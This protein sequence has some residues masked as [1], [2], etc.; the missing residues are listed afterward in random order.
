MFTEQDM[1]EMTAQA[2][3]AAMNAVADTEQPIIFQDS[4]K[5]FRNAVDFITSPEGLGLSTLYEY[6]RQYQIIRDFHSLL[7][8][9][10]NSP[11]SDNP[12]QPFDCWGR[13]PLDL[14]ED[15]LFEYIDGVL[16]C[17]Q[18][19]V[20]QSE[21]NLPR[22][23]TVVGISGMRSIGADTYVLTTQGLKRIKDMHPGA[24]VWN[25]NGKVTATHVIPEGKM[26]TRKITTAYGYSLTCSPIHPVLVYGAASS[27]TGIKCRHLPPGSDDVAYP[28]CKC[29]CGWHTSGS[30]RTKGYVR[31]HS[32]KVK[33]DIFKKWNELE[34]GDPLVLPINQRIFG[35]KEE[36]L[37]YAILLG[38]IVGDGC[39][40]GRNGLINISVSDKEIEKWVLRR[41]PRASIC[42]K[43]DTKICV[44][45]CWSDARLRDKIIASGYDFEWTAPSKEIPKSILEGNEETVIS[46]LRGLMEADGCASVDCINYT[47]VSK[48]LA[49]QVHLLFLNLGIVSCL[50]TSPTRGYK[51]KGLT[52]NTTYTIKIKGS[53]WIE[54][55]CETIGFLSSTKNRKALNLLDLPKKSRSNY[56]IQKRGWG[57]YIVVRVKRLEQVPDEELYDLHVPIGNSF[58]ANGIV[59]HNS[60]KTYMS[61]ALCLY[62]L[63]KDLLIDNPQKE[64]GIGPGQ[65]VNYTLCSTKSDQAKDTVFGALDGLHENSPWFGRYVATLKRRAKEQHIPLE[66][67]YVHN[68]GDIQ[69]LHKK[70]IIDNTGA[71]SAGIAGKTRKVVVMDEIARFIE[72]ESRMGVDLV[73]DTLRAS[74]LTLSNHGSKML[75]ISSPMFRT[76]KIMRLCYPQLEHEEAKRD[77]QTLYFHTPTWLFNPLFPREHPAI[78][79]RFAQDPVAARRDFGAEPPGAKD[80]WIPDEEKIDQCVDPNIPLLAVLDDYQH[81]IV[82]SGKRTDLVAKRVSQLDY[83]TTKTVTVAC[84]PGHVRDSFGMV[85]GY[86]A[87]VRT[88]RG[89]ENHLFVGMV[90][91]WE[92]TQRPKREVD[93]ASVL[94]V[95]KAFNDHWKLR[96]LVFDQWNSVLMVQ[97][98]QAAGIDAAK[99]SL[100]PEDWSVL[101]SLIYNKQVHLLSEARGGKSAKRLVW[102]LKNL[103]MS[104]SG[105]VDHSEYSS[106]DLAVC[107]AR[108][109]KSLLGEEAV[110]S[111]LF[112]QRS[113]QIGSVRHFRRP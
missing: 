63:H 43:K 70:L 1:L 61:A 42:K 106:S 50:S 110:Q 93:F 30:K 92:P 86:L 88:A 36:N 97:D 54:R 37:D 57:E 95:L 94:K 83:R 21:C 4:F 111:D 10:C 52:G 20:L 6:T 48:E 102:E 71:N 14:Q 41:H 11:T 91:A 15:V 26:P 107:L 103:Q 16:Q 8:P 55:F 53:Q 99:L 82:V 7:C 87:P 29:G 65:P 23:N 67:V 112:Q 66:K 40:K 80:P 64:W 84:D 3:Q 68:V 24:T 17:P 62:E 89:I 18:C 58:V 100:K 108:L 98:L 104:D 75:C 113:C 22:Y 59:S 76:D 56:H 73:Y 109:S 27:K 69:Y 38:L 79:Q 19:K 90:A 5:T 2:S 49:T 39:L 47:T 13:S 101:R 34:I 85:M 31:G 105:K 44:D 51:S 12:E 25:K 9:Q 72:T 78:V 96:K 28:L 46:F 45:L 60:G 77:D 74:L 32:S 81:S 35:R 33:P